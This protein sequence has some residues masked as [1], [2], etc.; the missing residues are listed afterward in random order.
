M[1]F[2]NAFVWIL[3]TTLAA[4]YA[5]GMRGA[6]IGGEKGAML[7]GAFVGLALKAFAG[8]CGGIGVVAAGLMGMT[9]GGIEPYGETIGLVLHNPHGS[10]KRIKGY[11]GLAFKGSLWFSVCGGFIAMAFSYGV[12]ST[13]DIRLFCV[14]IPV[15]QLIGYFIFNTPFNKEKGICPKI[16]FS[17]TRREEW[18]SNLLLLVAMMTMAVIRNDSIALLM[19]AFGFFFGGIG[20]IVAIKCFDITKQPLKNGKYLFGK[21]Y[22]SHLI[23]GWKI[24]EFVLG[25]FGG[26]G[27]SLAFCFGYDYINIYN[28]RISLNGV[29]YFD[30]H[31]D[32]WIPIICILCAAGIFAVNLISHIC[33]KQN[34]KVSSFVLDRIER[35]FYSVIP[36][37]FVL[38]GEQYSARFM[39]A[40]MLVFV[41]VI[42]L[43]FDRFKIVNAVTLIISAAV[44][45]ISYIYFV[46]DGVTPMKIIF[47]GT[48]PYIGGELICSIIKQKE[49]G[50]SIKSLFTESAFG[51]VFPAFVVM[52]ILIYAISAKIF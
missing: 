49:N 34:K 47:A 17:P 6:L 9:Y 41:V 23:D 35:I 20:W 19:M 33:D 30:E 15:V 40:F 5:W 14:L 44:I 8:P 36:M 52:S 51:T 13:K 50:K 18:G 26:F 16:S 12:Y 45:V 3:F 29:K 24:M 27:F 4:S 43:L 10:L 48:V 7:P 25:A 37:I 42:K 28:E 32:D 21:L 46:I 22:T 31:T 38:W 2:A 1:S 11:I 39:T